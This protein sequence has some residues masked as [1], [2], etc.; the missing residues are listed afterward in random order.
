MTLE[1]KISKEAAS[2][3]MTI[4]SD[5]GAEI[6]M[7]DLSDEDQEVIINSLYG[8]TNM[9]YSSYLKKHPEIK[10]EGEELANDLTKTDE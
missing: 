2:A 10:K 7:E 3:E 1:I 9:F 8:F 6:K 4:M 5:E